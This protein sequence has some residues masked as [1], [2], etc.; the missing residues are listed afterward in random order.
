M[1][2]RGIET[3]MRK[4]SGNLIVENRVRIVAQFLLPDLDKLLIPFIGSLAGRHKAFVAKISQQHAVIVEFIMFPVLHAI[5][6]FATN[7]VT[8][9]LVVV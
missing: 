8:G 7:P 6:I 9:F 4:M 3:E 2:M 1:I 5:N